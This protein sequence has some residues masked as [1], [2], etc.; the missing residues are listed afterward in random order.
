MNRVCLTKD[1]KLIEMQGGGKVDRSFND[2]CNEENQIA[3]N[4]KWDELEAM[5]LNTLKQNAINAGYAEADIEVKWVTDEEW[6]GIEEANKTIVSIADQKRHA[7]QSEAD[8]LWRE[9]QVLLSLEHPE[10]ENRRLEWLAKRAEIAARF[11]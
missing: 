5:R 7:Y 9:W 1:G 3:N 2:V 4:K 10:A 11:G 8:P 6:V